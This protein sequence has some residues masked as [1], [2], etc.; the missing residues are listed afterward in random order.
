MRVEIEDEKRE[1]K[2]EKRTKRKK[3]KERKK[4]GDIRPSRIIRNNP[5][6]TA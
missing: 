3:R 5:T 2:R 4:K 1:E 6:T